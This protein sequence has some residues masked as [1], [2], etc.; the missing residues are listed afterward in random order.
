MRVLRSSEVLWDLSSTVY[1]LFRVLFQDSKVPPTL[2]NL[3]VTQVVRSLES[4][5]TAQRAQSRA[6]KGVHPACWRSWLELSRIVQVSQGPPSPLHLSNP[7]SFSVSPSLFSASLSLSRSLDAVQVRSLEA[8]GRPCSHTPDLP[9]IVLGRGSGKYLMNESRKSVTGQW[10][11]RRT[12]EVGTLLSCSL[13][14]SSDS[15][16]RS[17][18]T[19]MNR[20]PL[21][22][23]FPSKVQD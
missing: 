12:R 4:L 8:S 20:L 13:P 23:A 21:L 11:H 16:L 2:P 19:C 18:C 15:G 5:R 14:T 6:P 7:P 22:V 17:I 1:F 10:R 3:A 9:Y